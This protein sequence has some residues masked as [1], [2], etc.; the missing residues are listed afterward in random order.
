MTCAARGAPL[1]AAFHD[2]LLHSEREDRMIV[3]IDGLA[4][5]ALLRRD[6]PVIGFD[7]GPGNRLLA[8][9]ARWAAPHWVL[10]MAVLGLDPDYVEAVVFACFA[11]GALAGE[12]PS[13]ASVTGARG[14]RVL[15]G[16]CRSG[17]HRM[18]PWVHGFVRRVIAHFEAPSRL[19]R[20]NGPQ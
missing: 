7:T 16:I 11:R 15:G 18:R 10:A 2:H 14:S 6:T 17:R 20:E 3:N 13:R 12:A 5:T 4:N 8:A 1:V 19:R 9:I